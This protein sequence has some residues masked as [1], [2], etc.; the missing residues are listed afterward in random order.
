MR[1]SA[2]EALSAYTDEMRD[3]VP[4]LL[5]TTTVDLCGRHWATSKE[6]SPE[7]RNSI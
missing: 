2:S 5:V 6:R 7:R 4:V 3:M 1:T